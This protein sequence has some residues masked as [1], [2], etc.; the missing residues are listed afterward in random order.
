VDRLVA[1]S[2][3]CLTVVDISRA[4]LRRAQARLPDAPVRWIE[5][6]VA[7]DW[8]PPRVDFWHDR[9]VFHFLVDGADR[10]RYVE[11]LASAVKPDGQVVIATF[12]LEGPSMCSGLPVM[13]YSPDTLAS[14]LGASFRLVQS[15]R[16]AHQ[17]PF[18]IIQEFWY[19][20]LKRV[21]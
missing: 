14:E 10:R 13:R 7:G 1:R 21:T 12:A 17:T 18:G 15:S 19:S 9:A 4:A 20:R 6:D 5:A 3:E 16:E 8:T 11:H 2:L